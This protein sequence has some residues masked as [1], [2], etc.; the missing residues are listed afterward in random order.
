MSHEHHEEKG[1]T[2]LYEGATGA[3][4]AFWIICVLT[5]IFC[6]VYFG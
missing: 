4:T 3:F 6:I 1:Q 2:F 5:F